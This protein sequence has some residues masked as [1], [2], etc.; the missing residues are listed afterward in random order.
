[1]KPRHLI[2]GLTLASALSCAHADR[3]D[4]LEFGE[5]EN[6]AIERLGAAKGN[7]SWRDPEGDLE[8]LGKFGDGAFWVSDKSVRRDWQGHVIF[9]MFKVY[10]K[11]K[12]FRPP[13][14]PFKRQKR[15][16]YTSTES[17]VEYVCA[18]KVF[19]IKA[20]SLYS[21]EHELLDSDRFPEDFG[22]F[23][24]GTVMERVHQKYCL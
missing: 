7:L 13:N 20:E 17:V 22:G 15:V 8:L 24:P 23:R 12:F 1:M 5:P 4:G 9:K 16:A 2:W 11:P 6:A 18:K 19:A 14:D 3:I 21:K 10:D